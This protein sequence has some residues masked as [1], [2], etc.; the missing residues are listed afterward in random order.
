MISPCARVR[1]TTEAR[2][3][4]QAAA[5]LGAIG[6]D[7]LVVVESVPLEPK[8]TVHDRPASEMIGL[9]LS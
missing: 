7:D 8:I 5:E 3:T 2:L 1:R 4:A 9:R 6:P